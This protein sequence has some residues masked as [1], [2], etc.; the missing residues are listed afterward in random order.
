M[1]MKGLHLPLP[2]L[3]CYMTQVGLRG[4]HPSCCLLCCTC[5]T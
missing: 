5:A 3:C 1:K 4:L 2:L